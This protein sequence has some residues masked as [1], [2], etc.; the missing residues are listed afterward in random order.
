MVGGQPLT[1]YFRSCW[2]QLA[3]G[4]LRGLLDKALD[5]LASD[6]AEQISTHAVAR[7]LWDKGAGWVDPAPLVA[8]LK[9]SELSAREIERRAGV[10]HD[11]L[12]RLARQDG[13]VLKFET[14]A[15]LAEVLGVD[16][17]KLPLARRHL[18]TLAMKRAQTRK[19]AANAALREKERAK[20]AK[21]HGGNIAEAFSLLRKCAQ[22]LDPAEHDFSTRE[23]KEHVRHAYAYLTKAEYE[24]AQALGV[25]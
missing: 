24:I 11:Q 13:R 4:E 10:S 14:A 9:H 21:R 18:N 8:A 15:A 5:E 25:E 22:V 23:A 17:A 19:R 16:Q 7:L 6:P 20:A 2:R 3:V 12:A 1:R